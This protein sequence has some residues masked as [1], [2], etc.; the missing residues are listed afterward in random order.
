M[1][2]F[3]RFT[4]GFRNNRVEQTPRLQLRPTW[5]ANELCVR[6]LAYSGRAMKLGGKAKVEP[7]VQL[8]RCGATGSGTNLSCVGFTLGQGTSDEVAQFLKKKLKIW[9]GEMF[10]L[11]FELW[12][13]AEAALELLSHE[14]A[15]APDVPPVR[16]IDESAAARVVRDPSAQVDAFSI[17]NPFRMRRSN[18]PSL[19][20]GRT[21][22]SDE[23][24]VLGHSDNPSA[25]E[26]ARERDGEPDT[27][28]KLAG[29]GGMGNEKEGE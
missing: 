28:A 29:A 25:N 17:R 24:N 6:F 11:S 20:L 14:G 22:A 2:L 19:T 3:L 21:Q 7:G 18:S 16:Y 10:W 12:E 8:K 9:G 5:S 13:D 4:R 15:T 23:W 26:D 1:A 27:N